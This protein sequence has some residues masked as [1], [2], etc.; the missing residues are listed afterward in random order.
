M[1]RKLVLT[2]LFGF[3]AFTAGVYSYPSLKDFLPLKDNHQHVNSS[4][5]K[6]AICMMQPHD[7]S[8]VKGVVLMSQTEDQKHTVIHGKL[9]GLKPG[10]FL[11]LNKSCL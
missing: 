4:Q 7:N 10:L 9:E 3:A 5:P 6:H 11:V 2:S 8:G 1:K